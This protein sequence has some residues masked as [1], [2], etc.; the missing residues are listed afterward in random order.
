MDLGMAWGVR[1]SQSGA[2]DCKAMGMT[3]GV[4]SWELSRKEVAEGGPTS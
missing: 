2:C 1:A 3:G 4:G